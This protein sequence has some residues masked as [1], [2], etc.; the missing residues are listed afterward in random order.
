[1][2]NS[3]IAERF[4]T[5]VSLLQMK[6]EKSF[7]VRAYQRAERTIERF[8]RDMDAMVAEG[9]DLTEIPGVGKA[10]SNKITELVITGK[11]SY[12]ER[13]E[14]EFPDGVL[15]LVEIPG[16]GP[17]T[18]VRLWKEL[19]VTSIDALEA[20]V[21]DGRVASLPRMG[22]KSA[23]NI[24]RAIQFAKSKSDRFPI[25][26]AM[27]ISRR[28]TAYLRE[29]CDGIS[30]LVVCGSLRRFEETVGDLDLVCVTSDPAGAMDAMAGMDGVA[31][32]LGHGEKKTSV[33]LDSGMQ[34]DL[35]VCEPQHL[36]AMLQYFTGNLHH[37]VRLREIASGLGLSLNEYGLKDVEIGTL[38][39]YPTEEAL[40]QRLG[41]QYVPPEL[42]Q[43]AGEVELARNGDIPRLV[44]LSDIKGDLHTHTDWSD[45]RDSMEEMILEA[46]ALGLEY[47]AVTDHSV[48]RGIANGLSV[49]RLESHGRR[50]KELESEIGGIRILRGT[51]M[52]IRADGSLDYSD[53]VLDKLDWVVASVHSAMSQDS[54]TMTERIIKAMRNPRV[55]AI[56]HLSTRLIGERP[57]V[58]AD[59]DAIFR[60]AADT[61][62]ALEING[63]L[64]RLDLKD[65]HVS[66]ARELGA[67]LVINTDA[68]TTEGLGNMEYGVSLARRGWC[69]PSDI[70]NCMGADEFVAWLG[71]KRN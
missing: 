19:D 9:E 46:R 12:L 50:L 61:G 47:I 56:G 66:R 36:G 64:E 8:P 20:A 33:V 34:V 11:M 5:I 49:E 10:I 14:S 21:E 18:I 44:D 30:E 38:E 59:Y 23:E 62:T 1:M 29:N 16:L 70:L 26:R 48:G 27:D 42:R 22:K 43:G 17:K 55:L 53:E 45:G 35:R 51:E 13:L 3:E 57:P 37:N 32:V 69:Q 67:A 15:D 24:G 58:D 52:D 65:A 31:N 28:L 68:H 25:A 60:A 71:K 54:A 7:T 63:S 39:T 41:L 6:G 4:G 2:T 40:Y